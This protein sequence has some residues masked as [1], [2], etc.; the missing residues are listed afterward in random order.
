MLDQFASNTRAFGEPD[1]QERLRHC[2]VNIIGSTPAALYALFN[3]IGLGVQHINWFTPPQ[4]EK[5]GIYS[6]SLDDHIPDAINHFSVYAHKLLPACNLEIY[7][8]SLHEGFM[9]PGS[10]CIE[11]SLDHKSIGRSIH[12]SWGSLSRLAVIGSSPVGPYAYVRTDTP[13]SSSAYRRLLHQV[14]DRI[15]LAETGC[16]ESMLVQLLGAIRSANDLRRNCFL[17]EERGEHEYSA[18]VTNNLSSLCHRFAPNARSE[19]PLILGAGGVGTFCMLS[20]CFFGCRRFRVT[21]FDTVERHNLNRQI[22]YAGS[23]GAYKSQVAAQRLQEWFGVEASADTLRLDENTRPVFTKE[24]QG[25][26]I[27][28]CV[29]N[30]AAR[31]IADSVAVRTNTRLIEGGCDAFGGIVTQYMPGHSHSVSCQRRLYRRHDRP[32]ED[33]TSCARQA[34]P[35]V[36]MPNAAVGT[37]MAYLDTR[38]FALRKDTAFYFDSFCQ[39]HFY[40][41]PITINKC[42]CLT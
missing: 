32:P 31:R 28:C 34:N 29:D 7:P 42:G 41:D 20:L 22:L 35:S 40:A 11:A 39:P 18:D 2:K 38:P 14:Q 16:P 9:Q 15:G 21:D 5:G 27:Y 8:C 24:V 26:P 33:E 3:C 13:G 19:I 17:L 36:I 6:N 10:F 12:A 1:L 25:R 23:E 30:F 37:Y 4:T